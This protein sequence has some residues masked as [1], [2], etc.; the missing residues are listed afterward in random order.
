MTQIARTQIAFYGSTP[1]YAF[2]FDDLGFEGTTAKLGQLMKKGDIG[3]MASTITDEM[4]THFALPARWDDMA[5]AL[6]Q[7]YRG[8]AARVVSYLAM[9]DISENPSHLGRWGEIAKAVR[10]C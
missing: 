2:Q 1:N 4:L 10:A 5:D 7:R 9:G 3:G 8:K 6:I